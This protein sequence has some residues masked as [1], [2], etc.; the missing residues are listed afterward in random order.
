[1]TKELIQKIK[2]SLLEN[3]DNAREIDIVRRCIGKRLAAV[4]KYYKLKQAYVAHH[5]GVTRSKLS[6]IENGRAPLRCESLF[7]LG[8]LGVPTG[9]MLWV[10]IGDLMFD[11]LDLLDND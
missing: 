9:V 1:M 2:H 5:I 7:M 8:E 4:R 6:N 10:V 3:N 11:N